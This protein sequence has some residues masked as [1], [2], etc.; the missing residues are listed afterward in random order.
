MTTYPP[1]PGFDGHET[2][3]WDGLN[4]YERS[5]TDEE[6]ALLDAHEQAGDAA[7]R[8]VEEQARDNWFA[9]IRSELGSAA[10]PRARSAGDGPMH[11][12]PPA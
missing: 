6:A 10:P 7:D 9:L 4:Y 5:C 1:P 3:T 8:Q 12:A 2:G 11:G